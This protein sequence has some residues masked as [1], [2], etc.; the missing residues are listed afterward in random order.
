MIRR[1][2]PEDYGY[3]VKSWVRSYSQ[4]PFALAVGPASEAKAFETPKGSV[5]WSAGRTYQAGH[6]ALVNRLVRQCSVL[7][8]ETD[9]GEGLIID[10]FAVGEP[11]RRILHYV[12]VRELERGSGLARALVGEML[13]PGPVT[14]THQ[15]PRI[16]PERLPEGWRF[17]AYPLMGAA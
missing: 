6:Y 8:A 12:F 13:G 15:T 11:E 1:A 2:Q 10:G 5:R 16:R 17:T 14:Y 9:T 7:V 3:I 4:S